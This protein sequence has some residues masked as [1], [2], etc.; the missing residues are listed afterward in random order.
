LEAE[1]GK[2]LRDYYISQVN[3]VNGLDTI[4]TGVCLCVCAQLTR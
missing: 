4:M 1:N 3:A 2:K